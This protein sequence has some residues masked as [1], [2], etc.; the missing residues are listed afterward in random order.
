MKVHKTTLIISAINIIT[1]CIAIYV[2]GLYQ[3]RMDIVDSKHPITN[4]AILEINYSSGHRGGSSV[5][6]AYN[7]A[8]Y[9]IGI[10]SQQCKA[11]NVE[12]LEFYYDTENNT[13]FEKN[14]LNKRRVLFFFGL[15]LCSLLLWAYPEMRKGGKQ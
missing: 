10:T 2:A 9:Y 4:F 15:F 7:G 14:N 8:E 1:L 3:H 11:E 12:N 6:V 5:K 13:I